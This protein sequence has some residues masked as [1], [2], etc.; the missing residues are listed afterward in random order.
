M[1]N[2]GDSGVLLHEHDPSPI[3]LVNKG[4]QGFTKTEIPTFMD[5]G[6]SDTMFVSKEA[7]TEYMATAP[8]TGDTAK[9]VDGGFEIVGQ[10]KVTQ[11]YLV[12]S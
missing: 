11:T 4:F 6:A 3:A 1:N 10:G 5:S 2:S 12:D 9:A 8:R 7:F